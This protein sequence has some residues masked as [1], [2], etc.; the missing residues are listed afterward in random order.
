MVAHGFGLTLSGFHRS[1]PERPDVSLL[2]EPVGMF[3]KE[4]RGRSRFFFQPQSFSA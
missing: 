2:H 3:W 4:A 1:F